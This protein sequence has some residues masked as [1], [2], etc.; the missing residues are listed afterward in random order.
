MGTRKTLYGSDMIINSKDF[1]NNYDRIFRKEK[2][3]DTNKD[4]QTK[5]DKRRKLCHKD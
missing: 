1:L 5:S 3:E 4:K 2:A